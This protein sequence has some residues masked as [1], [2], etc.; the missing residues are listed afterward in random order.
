MSATVALS[1]IIAALDELAEGRSAH[2][3]L[4]SGEIVHVPN[5]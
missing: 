5:P 1:R 2:L 3:E 4:A